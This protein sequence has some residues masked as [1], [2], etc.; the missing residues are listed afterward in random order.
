MPLDQLI[1]L[2]IVQGITEFL[3]ISSTAHIRLMNRL[4]LEEGQSFDQMAGFSS[5]EVALHVGS[6]FAVLLFFRKETRDA[7]VGPFTLVGDWRAK[8]ELR[9]TSK[10]ALLLAIATIPAILFGLA[11]EMFGWRDQLNADALLE[12]KVIGW[13]TVVFGMLLYIS[14][15]F[16]KS[17]RTLEGWTLGSAIWM[18]LAQAIA[19][20]P[21]V[22][23]SGVC[24]TMGRFLGYSRV[25][26]ARIAMLMAIPIILVA[27]GFDGLKLLLKNEL[28]LGQDA[29]IAAGLSFVSAY[30]ALALMMRFLTTVSFTP[31]VVYRLIL[32]GILLWTAYANI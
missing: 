19:L 31:Y 10:L 4:M 7:I 13:T 1:V 22:S 28:E 9:P 15:R 21:G 20:I 11:M 6:L 29:A 18:G 2:A 12:L 26:A 8:R 30:F 24:M 25:E 14:D 23:R 16:F 17:E 3:P 27:G 32:G 5:I